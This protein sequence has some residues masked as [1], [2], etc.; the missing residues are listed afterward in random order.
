MERELVQA[1]AAL[2]L[3]AADKA[4]VELAYIYARVIDQEPDEAKRL[5]PLLLTVLCELGMTPRS[6]A[7]L[8]KG[9]SHGD[10]TSALDELRQRRNKRQNTA[11]PMDPVTA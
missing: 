11:A 10:N 6:R 8:V 7:A 2:D 9:G 1:V 4:A 3:T 5:G